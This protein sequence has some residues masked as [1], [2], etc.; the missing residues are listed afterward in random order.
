MVQKSTNKKRDYEFSPELLKSKPFELWA[1][2]DTLGR[3]LIYQD[4][5]Y[6]IA[7]DSF[8]SPTQLKL[9]T[10][11]TIGE[12]EVGQLI[13]G[14]VNYF[15]KSYMKLYFIQIN[16]AHKGKGYSFK[17]MNCLLSILRP[18]TQ[19]IITNY[20]D[21]LNP[22]PLEKLFTSLGGYINKFG[23]FEIKNPKLN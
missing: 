14:V 10:K 21:R 6:K 18:E 3:K 17:M 15:D 13:C 7:V 5:D 12:K 11:A 8:N 23:Y 19:G 4:K 22:E 2:V 16:D 9:Y 1:T 20:S